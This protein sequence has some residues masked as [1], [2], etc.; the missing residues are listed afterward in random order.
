M[1]K[2]YNAPIDRAT[3][4]PLQWHD[5]TRALTLPDKF[6]QMR[7]NKSGFAKTAWR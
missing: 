1:P 5:F 2:T 7:S 6:N 3:I 4:A